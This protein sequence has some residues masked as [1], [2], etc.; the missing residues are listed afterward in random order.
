MGVRCEAVV[1][2]TVKLTEDGNG[3]IV[4][5]YNCSESEQT[6]DVSLDG[7][8]MSEIVN[9]MEESIEAKTD[10]KL[11]LHGFELVNVRFVK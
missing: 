10:G 11:T 5:F 8:R 1:L 9:I 2:E 4:R 3:L 7:Y 6:A